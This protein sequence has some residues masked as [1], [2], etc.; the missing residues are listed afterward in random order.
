[1]TAAQKTVRIVPNVVV[2]S[3]PDAPSATA[4][5]GG[6]PAR[7]A[8]VPIQTPPKSA[9]A[10]PE[11]FAQ[12]ASISQF[13]DLEIEARRCAD[14]DELRFA[15]VNATRK[16]AAFE[17]GF[18]AEPT[19]TGGWAVTRTSSVS[20]ID[21][22]APLIRTID[23]WLQHPGHADHLQKGEPRSADLEAEFKDWGLP[24]K[25]IAFPHALWL[26]LK[27][28]DG[29]PLAALL[30]LKTETW[31]PQH[32]ALLIP[33]AG[34]YGHAWAALLPH[35]ASSMG[36]ARAHM[37]RSRLGL[38]GLLACS[39]AAFIPVPMS[40][41]APAE[42][43]PAQPMLVTAPIDGVV[44][45][46]LVPP[47]GWVEKDTP[48]VKFV[49][50]K[51]RND[52][53][54]AL[55]TKGVAEARHFKVV[56][57][58]IATQ[59]D[60]QDLATAKAELDVAHAELAY[61]IELLKRSEIRAT[62]S[63]LLIYSAKSD[64]LGKPI[65]VGE[66]LMEIGDPANTEVKIELPVSDAIV[67]QRGGAV[68]LFLDGDPLRAIDG[69][70][71]QTSYRPTQTAEQQLAFRVQAGFNDGQARRIGLRGIARVNGEQVSLW[72]YLLRRPIAALRQRMGL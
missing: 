59:K 8:I 66:R 55:R 70:I 69:T 61:A 47:G 62:R 28:R 41:L 19:L 30:L 40:A 58:A 23:A 1:M 18:L 32:S 50:V 38:A 20:K 22:N 14:L 46:V 7:P 42:V 27:A 29:R 16:I 68:S 54:V 48:I 4:R 65:A 56:Q 21:R 64:L 24:S 60:M 13:I 67:L 44:A 34:A 43:V 52:V 17:L 72:F 15:I 71:T 3:N 36:R 26:P 11:P 63:G 49:D 35:S 2:Q 33:L 5:S 31:R 10:A 12:A 45:D 57:S 6:S 37:S 25:A 53:E 39:F 51:L 9:Q